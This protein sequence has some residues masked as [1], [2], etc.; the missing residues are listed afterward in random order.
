MSG[1]ATPA[2]RVP[3]ANGCSETGLPLQEEAK[4]RAGCGCRRAQ[5][6]RRL[7]PGCRRCLGYSLARRPPRKGCSSQR[8]LTDSA[9]V[10]SAAGRRGRDRAAGSGGAEQGSPGGGGAG[11]GPSRPSAHCRWWGGRQIGR[12][13]PEASLEGRVGGRGEFLPA[14]PLMVAGR[15]LRGSLRGA[16]GSAFV[17]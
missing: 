14:R 11:G 17:R 6:E 7:A 5:G 4:Q 12:R 10:S 2:F 1:G 3:V 13:F 15:G 8:R 16:A 9:R